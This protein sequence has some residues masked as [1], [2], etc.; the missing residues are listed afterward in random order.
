MRSHI[1]LN[2]WKFFDQESWSQKYVQS[3]VFCDHTFH[4]RRPIHP[5]DHER[6]GRQIYHAALA[7]AI[8]IWRHSDFYELL[9]NNLFNLRSHRQRQRHEVVQHGQPDAHHIRPFH[10]GNGASMGFGNYAIVLGVFVDKCEFFG[11]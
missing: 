2:F 4:G 1:R 5:N 10:S 7:S 8:R 9:Y 6:R 11:N 3:H